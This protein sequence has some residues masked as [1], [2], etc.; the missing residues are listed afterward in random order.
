LKAVTSAKSI[1]IR[2]AITLAVTISS[3][4][5]V[6]SYLE[7]GSS[8]DVGGSSSQVGQVSISI[9]IH[10]ILGLITIGIISLVSFIVVE[11]RTKSPLI[12]FKFITNKIILPA[13]I[14]LLFSFVAMFTVYQTIPILVRSPSIVGGFEGDVITTA[15]I[16]LPFMIVFLLFAP[17]SGF[18]ISKLGNLKPTLIGTIISTIGFF[19][20]FLLHSTETMLAG[21]LAIIATGL[22]LSQV[23]GFNIVLESTPRQFSGISLGITVLLNL[24]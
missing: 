18:I 8:N 3:F 6:L 7:T 13:N 4:L 22:S 10:I 21:S 20:I 1:D 15:N 2:G 23:G 16:Q 9:P 12:D 5:I 14:L 17:S 19:S 24:I 11:K